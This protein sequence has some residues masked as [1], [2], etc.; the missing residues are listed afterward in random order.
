MTLKPVPRLGAWFDEDGAHWR[1][2]APNHSKLEVVLMSVAD[3]ATTG[4][5]SLTQE[6]EF[7]TGRLEKAPAQ[8]HYKL[9]VDGAGPF[10][11]P[12]SRSQPLGVHGPSELTRDHY[13]WHDEGWAGRPLADMIIEEI[14]VGTA[15]PE[16]RFE[17]LISVLGH[18]RDLGVTAIELLP[19]ASF[20][21]QRNWGYDGVSL[22]APA[23]PYGGPNGLRLLVDAA[24][25]V[26]LAVI[27]DVV[28]NHFGPD[29]NYL[30]CFSDRYF[31]S[32]HKTPW[33]DGINYDGAGS[34]VVRDLILSNVEMWIRDYHLDGLRLD[35]THAIVDDSPRHI[36]EEIG[37]RAR[38]A[39][40][41]RHVVV[42][43]EDDRNEARL[44]RPVESGGYALDAVWADD[45]HHGLRRRLA[46]DTE[47][48]FADFT[49]SSADLAKTFM[50]GWFYQGQPSSHFGHKRGTSSK[51]LPLRRFVHCIQNHDQ[52]GNRALGDRLGE[53]VTSEAQRVLAGLLLMGPGTPLLFMGQEWNASAPFQYFTDHGEELGRAVTEGRR[54]EFSGF[55]A[56]S[57]ASIPDPQAESTFLRSKLDWS[58][59][60]QPGH[61]EMLAWYR[62]L[63]ALRHTHPGFIRPRD[64]SFRAFAPD[65]NSLRFEY[66]GQERA[67]IVVA[68]FEGKT[69]QEVNGLLLL[70]SEAPEFGGKDAVVHR[71]GRIVGKGPALMIFEG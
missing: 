55:S 28:Y 54:K 29:G 27:L 33:G 16:G 42:F 8:L 4:T 64:D 46:G 24:H 14:H 35:A 44:L 13:E 57:G 66:R 25:S 26:G 50:E 36:L 5:L 7:F 9:R 38:A 37:E 19:V 67:L 40:P 17:S 39:A 30:S 45:L 61:R 65:E 56:F 23:A 52:V 32:R 20:P 18:V 47:G 10:P 41:K 2:W 12:W 58:E 62:A 63:L 1:V 31:T 34:S 70:S 53:A 60:A 51:G 48:Y 49:G 71:D 69:T 59:L 3:S 6:G 21:G 15:T 43:A 22:F 11:D 68:L